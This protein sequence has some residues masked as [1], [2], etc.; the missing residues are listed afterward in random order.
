MRVER[1]YGNKR[2]EIVPLAE[3]RRNGMKIDWEGYRA[4]QPTVGLGNAV[5][6]DTDLKG[7]GGVHQLEDVFHSWRISPDSDEAQHLL[8][9]AR[10]ENGTFIRIC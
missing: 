5:V 9:D 3:A 1:R 7:G 4:P 6:L 10:F 2:V 8:H